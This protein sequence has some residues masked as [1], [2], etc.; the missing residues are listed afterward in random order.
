MSP[1]KACCRLS[2]GCEIGYGRWRQLFKIKGITRNKH[3]KVGLLLSPACGFLYIFYFIKRVISKPLATCFWWAAAFLHPFSPCLPAGGPGENLTCWIWFWGE[4][5]KALF[6]VWK[7][8]N[9]WSLSY[10]SL[11]FFL[12]IFP[13]F[14]LFSCHLAS[15][16]LFL[17]WAT[18]AHSSG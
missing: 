15:T 12:L 16:G 4:E 11:L 6:L 17:S 2:K 14:Q 18:R 1:L 13:L 3:L 8:R 5:L 10:R 7:Q 9:Y